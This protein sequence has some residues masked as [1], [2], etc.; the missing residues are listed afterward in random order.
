V[1][2]SWR[3]PYRG[4]STFLGSGGTDEQN[5]RAKGTQKE[6]Q[7]TQEERTPRRKEAKAYQK[8]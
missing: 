5:G 2:H 1:C 4:K 8:E 7:G 6:N 3:T